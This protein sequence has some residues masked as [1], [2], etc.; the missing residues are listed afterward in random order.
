MSKTDSEQLDDL[1]K[2]LKALEK[3]QGLDAATDNEI[4]GGDKGFYIFTSEEERRI[5]EMNWRLNRVEGNETLREYIEA[6]D[7]VTLP[8]KHFAVYP[9]GVDTTQKRID[10]LRE[11]I[12]KAEDE[13]E[14]AAKG[15]Q[16]DKQEKDKGEVSKDGLF[17]SAKDTLRNDKELAAHFIVYENAVA[18]MERFK[19]RLFD[20]DKT[21]D[22]TVNMS[23]L[24]GE[25]WKQ[26]QELKK[27]LEDT[28]Y[29]LI[30]KIGE[31]YPGREDDP[32]VLDVVKDAENK[33]AEAVWPK[34]EKKDISITDDSRIE[35][36]SQGLDMDEIRRIIG[37]QGNPGASYGYRELI[38]ATIKEVKP[39]YDEKALA[40]IL[41]NMPK[42]ASEKEAQELRNMLSS[43][44]PSQ[45]EV[46]SAIPAV[47]QLNTEVKG[48]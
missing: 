38:D 14:K 9:E 44:D 41:K 34:D 2:R 35:G 1:E 20:E 47:A 18:D 3:A 5:F 17:N 8:S 25:E 28:K 11:G 42:A 30:H 31:R 48:R 19:K 33:A 39:V 26:Y 4:Y 10:A 36:Y 46:P 29:G 15:Q 16:E 6:S 12:E 24:T 23:D 40:D 7:V 22:F 13:K 27:I 32:L 45:P 21:K 37:K 43:S